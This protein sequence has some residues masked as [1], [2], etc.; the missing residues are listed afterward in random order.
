M[1]QNLQNARML[2][3]IQRHSPIRQADFNFAPVIFAAFALDQ[4]VAFHG[5]QQLVDLRF[6]QL[7]LLAQLCCGCGL[8]T[9]V[10]FFIKDAADNHF[11][12][13]K[14][15]NQTVAADDQRH[16]DPRLEQLLLYGGGDGL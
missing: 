15:G 10:P 14:T 11:V 8:L 2:R 5:G 9:G 1:A 13:G 16:V 7:H 6:E 4:P 3:C 12:E